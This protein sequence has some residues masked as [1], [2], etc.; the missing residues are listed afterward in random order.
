MVTDSTQ[1]LGQSLNRCLFS[2]VNLVA[3]S[4]TV[5]LLE[6]IALST[7]CFKDSVLVPHRLI[8]LLPFDIIIFAV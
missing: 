4:T 3:N 8:F 2:V 7:H 6:P 1:F 5:P